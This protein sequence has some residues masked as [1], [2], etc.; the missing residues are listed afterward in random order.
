MTEAADG[1][2]E[3]D[4]PEWWAVLEGLSRRVVGLVADQVTFTELD[5]QGDARRFH[6]VAA[7]GRLEGSAT[8]A[9][10][11]A[12]GLHHRRLLPRPLAALGTRPPRL[13]ETKDT[14]LDDELTAMLA[15]PAEQFLAVGSPTHHDD[16][17]DVLTES[18]RLFNKYHTIL[19]AAHVSDLTGPKTGERCHD[20]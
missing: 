3:P 2:I 13:G 20:Q 18:R 17:A 5:D 10:S 7:H 14:T 16:H 11:A 19:T 1:S 8:D 6:Y 15:A 12:V 4:R 9:I